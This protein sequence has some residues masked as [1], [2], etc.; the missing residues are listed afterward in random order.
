MKTLATLALVAASALTVT[1][2]AASAQPYRDHDNGYRG[3]LISIDQR[4]EQLQRRIDRGVARGDLT[5]REAYR[6][7]SQ[8]RDIARLE[9][10]YRMNGLSGWERA[11]LDNRLDRL[12]AQVRFERN[13]RQEYGYGYR[14]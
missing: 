10:R 6:L 1:A 3:A 11:D 4:Q 14:H 8:M 2:T 12:S 7:Q 13:D 9:A 5:R